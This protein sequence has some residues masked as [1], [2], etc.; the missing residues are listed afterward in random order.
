[1]YYGIVGDYVFVRRRRWTGTEWGA[2]ESIDCRG[3]ALNPVATADDMDLYTASSQDMGYMWHRRRAA[4][5]GEFGQAEELRA[6]LPNM[7]PNGVSAN[8]CRLYFHNWV[9]G[10]GVRF[11]VAER[12]E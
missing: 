2:E 7:H 1:M 10:E 4:P 8:G 11:Y 9:S 5:G 3:S 6:L 12:G